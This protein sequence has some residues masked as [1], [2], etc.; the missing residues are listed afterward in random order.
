[1]KLQCP[2]L[3]RH[4]RGRFGTEREPVADLVDVGA[5]DV[6]ARNLHPRGSGRHHDAA[7]QAEHPAGRRGTDGGVTA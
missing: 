1:M 7:P 4:H 5:E 6:Q 2:G 3:F